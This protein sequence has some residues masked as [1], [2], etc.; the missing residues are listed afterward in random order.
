MDRRC[1]L[2]IS[3]EHESS[4]YAFYKIFDEELID[5]SL[6]DYIANENDK[7]LFRNKSDVLYSIPRQDCIEFVY[8]VEKID[9]KLLDATKNPDL[10]NNLY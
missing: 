1:L 4:G 5:I 9:G 6:V 7:V 10:K 3:L 2:C 8:Y